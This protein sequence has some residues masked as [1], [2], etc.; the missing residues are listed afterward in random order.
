MFQ[1]LHVLQLPSFKNRVANS[2]FWT[3]DAPIL[4]LSHSLALP[5]PISCQIKRPQLRTK[6][7]PDWTNYLSAHRTESFFSAWHKGDWYINICN[8]TPIKFLSRADCWNIEVRCE[9]RLNWWSDVRISTV[10]PKPLDCTF[11]R[12][13]LARI[14][15]ETDQGLT[16]SH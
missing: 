7:C 2:H 4:G 15:P 6:L 5:K 11:Q 14:E 9:E 10:H 16:L 8:C 13:Q 12:C 1:C 3:W